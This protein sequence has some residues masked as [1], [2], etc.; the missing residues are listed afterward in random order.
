[1]PPDDENNKYLLYNTLS[2]A[3]ILIDDIVINAEKELDLNKIKDS[4]VDSLHKNG[5]LINNNIDELEF[6][7]ANFYNQKKSNILTLTILPTLDCN[8]K[9]KYCFQ[10]A[11][12]LYLSKSLIDKTITFLSDKITKEK[13]IDKIAIVWF[14]GEPLLDDC[15]DIIEYFYAQIQP[16]IKKNKI[17]IGARVITNGSMLNKELIN[18][19]SSYG[20]NSLQ[21]TLDGTKDIHDK[22]KGIPIYD[23]ILR[24]L[25]I[26]HQSKISTTIRV[27]MTKSN[28]DNIK[29]LISD[30]SNLK[31]QDKI[32]IYFAPVE[33]INLLCQVNT[34]A[35]L[36][37]KEFSVI[38]SELIDFMLAKGFN[39]NIP[40][41]AFMPCAV[42]SFN[43]FVID[44]DG[45]VYTCYDSIYE[46]ESFMD[47]ATATY[48]NPNNFYKYIN[49]SPYDN[50]ECTK[51]K[52]F[53]I[54]RGG[55]TRKAI[56]GKRSCNPRKYNLNSILKSIYKHKMKKSM[57]KEND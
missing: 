10:P 20:V 22:V 46:N 28:A 45:K 41:S 51:C 56:E 49:Y 17:A 53:P 35:L 34:S 15:I 1:M 39:F 38:E 23:H 43:N 47:I 26:L 3:L 44:P 4:W 37:A 24:C 9:C 52:I 29:E 30:L 32:D 50:A 12:K 14:G 27:N 33:E 19:L 25:E 18:K 11:Q 36:T 5:F 16:I 31:L 54:C 6:Q 55:C 21:I 57:A 13:N 48:T 7:K 2:N 8:A 40:S 42:S